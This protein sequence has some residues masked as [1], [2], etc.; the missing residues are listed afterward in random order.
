MSPKNHSK[1]PI[2]KKSYI[3]NI[4][5]WNIGRRRFV[6]SLII[7]GAV[8]QLPFLN[9]CNSNIERQIKPNNFFS[10]ED[11]EVLTLVLNILFPDDGNGPG[12]IELNTVDYI[13][14]N[15]LDE[16]DD[17][18]QQ[19]YLID[20]V[21]WTKE[22]ANENYGITFL[23]L[24]DL[25]KEDLIAKMSGEN[26]GKDWLSMLLTLIMESLLID[27]VYNVNKKEIGWKWL[28]HQ[29]GVPRPNAASI[30]PDFLNTI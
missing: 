1:K 12:I 13:L 21:K 9:S 10:I 6:Q 5:D 16:R 28:S 26:W 14:W 15:L 27:E 25:E 19:K 24:N 8:M 11:T 29:P 2:S 7:G 23:N 18:S 17:P 20:G 3:D 4:E 30:Y 22:Y